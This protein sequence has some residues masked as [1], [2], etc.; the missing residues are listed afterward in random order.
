MKNNK[1]QPMTDEQLGA[2][3]DNELRNTIGTNQAGD[4]ISAERAKNLMMYLNRPVGD[5]EAG[6][7]KVQSSAIH[8]VVE[9]L[10][11]ATLAPFISADKVVEVVPVAPDDEAYAEQ[12]GAYL[13][14][15]FMVDNDGVKIQYVWQ[16]DALLQKN[17]FV[18]AEWCEKKKTERKTQ[19]VDAFG[20]MQIVNDPEIEVLK[21]A[22]FAGGQEIDPDALEQMIEMQSPEIASFEFEIDYRRTYTDGRVVVQNIAPEHMIVAKS[23]KDEETARIIGFQDQVS[24]SDLRQEGYEESK[25]E[26]INFGEEL[27]YDPANERTVR[28]EA[29]GGMVTD[30]MDSTDPA[31][32]LAWRTVVWARVDFDG[33]GKAELRKIV[34]AGQKSNGGVIIYNEEAD[35]VPIVSF[36]PIIMPHQIFGRC[37]A[38]EAREAQEAETAMMRMMM[39]A[40]Y[41]TVYPRWQL[42]EDGIADDTWD[43]LMNNI[44]NA[45]V[46][47]RQQGAVMPLRDSPDIG[48]AYNVLEYWERVKE[49]RT[50]ITR[51][52]AGVDV[53]VMNN[54]SATQS[55]I[56]ANATSVRKEL[57]LRLYAESLSKLFRIIN[58]IIIKNQD[59][60]RLMRLFPDREPINIDPRY[61]NA[62]MDVRVRVGLGTGTK[63][64]QLN[65]LMSI[66]Q[67]QMGDMQLGLPTVDPVKLYNT[68][69]R[70][71]EFSGLSSPELYFNNPD[72]MMQGN[73]P[74]E[75][76]AMLQQETQKAFEAGKAQAVAE[77][78][79]AELDI[80]K[81][82]MQV[83]MAMQDKELAFK[84]R[85]LAVKAQELQVR[86][87][88]NRAQAMGYSV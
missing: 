52:D 13:N 84:Q 3:L 56:Q 78:K 17:G 43:D 65:A 28:E 68:R 83:D 74:P 9:A 66:N 67:I 8:D 21:Y 80:K 76:Q 4:E 69:A 54:K 7:S 60:P 23:A 11:P 58:R 18:V 53:D 19:K 82:E 59:K 62:D 77:T 47:V 72:G 49:R 81:Q 27:E 64:Q 75:M 14:H 35:E 26:Q 79:A 63:D 39:D 32:R 10:L 29:Q 34:R 86:Q 36:T 12:C 50:P 51:Q 25:L 42:V 38:D 15:I 2:F 45:P 22:G 73:M 1:P 33:D 5:E 46:R 16:K 88:E 41:H 70:L 57:I 48:A 37:P 31:S 30:H 71:I 85:E 44:P 6:R 20:F 24:L 61:W 87:E 40:T 55:Q